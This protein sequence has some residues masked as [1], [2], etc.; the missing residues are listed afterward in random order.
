VRII[1]FA[2][3]MVCMAAVALGQDA[4]PEV[5]RDLAPT[6]KLRAAINLVNTVIAQRHS[7]A[8]T[9]KG[10]SAD[11]ARELARRLGVPIEYVIFY[12]A[13]KEFEAAK[14][15]V[16]DI[17]FFAL[18][19]ERATQVDFT[20]PYVVIQGGYLVAN[21]SP[22]HSIADAD[23]PGTRIAVGRGSVYDL[24]LTRTLK[25]AELVRVSPAGL[26][27]ILDEYYENKL[28][29]AAFITI[30]LAAFAKGDPDTRLVD[31][32]FMDI[33][34]AVATPK[35]RGE[36]GRRYLHAFME[37]MKASGYVEAALLRSGKTEAAVAPPAREY[38]AESA[39]APGTCEPLP[40]WFRSDSTNVVR[41]KIGP[42]EG[43]PTGNTY[44]FMP[45]PVKHVIVHIEP[46]SSDTAPYV[47]KLITRYTDDSIFEPIVA[48]IVP[49]ANQP[50]KWGPIPVMARKVPHDK[51][52]DAFNVKVQEN[53]AMDPGAKGFS[54]GVWVEGCN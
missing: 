3:V 4:S 5:V 36:A 34:Q 15:G 22:V 47:V 6:G 9:P 54:Y 45:H 21:D 12:G 39:N 20:A 24:Y 49:T 52:A 1:L 38:R 28:D 18:D 32:T 51:I 16:W 11:L 30:P 27:T 53:Y 41:E 29:V 31:G 17:G 14:R 48:T 43:S 35:G 10:V 25:H 33:E 7:N 44:F 19:P 2:V 26:P 23:R 37:E 8:G 46:T 42:N 13:G 50:F 40:P